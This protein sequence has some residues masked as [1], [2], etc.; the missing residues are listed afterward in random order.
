M[1]SSSVAFDAT[2]GIYVRHIMWSSFHDPAT[3][4]IFLLKFFY[5]DPATVYI[6]W[7]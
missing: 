3:V 6:K 1:S 4:Y 5:Y 7:R 2:F